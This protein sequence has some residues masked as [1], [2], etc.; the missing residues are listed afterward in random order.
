ME[1]Q[2]LDMEQQEC[3]LFEGC[4]GGELDHSVRQSRAQ[5]LRKAK[6]TAIAE[7]Y[8]RSVMMD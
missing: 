4:P 6:W 2:C 8:V 5:D 1:Q 7:I 3:D